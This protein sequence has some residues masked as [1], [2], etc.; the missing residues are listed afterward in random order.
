[1]IV[2]RL[3]MLGIT[4]L[5]LPM[6]I[7]TLFCGLKKD[8]NRWVFSWISGQVALWAGFLAICVP[9]ILLKKS[10]QLVCFLFQGY[11]ILLVCIALLVIFIGYKKGKYTKRVSRIHNGNDN[12]KAEILLWLIFG[13]LLIIQLLCTIMLAYEEGDDA[14][15]L[16]VSTYTEN[17][18]T[19]YLTI[20][21][22]GQYTALDAR[23]GLAPFPIWIAYLARISGIE[24]I[25]VA[26][27][28]LPLTLLGMCYG[29][30]YLMAEK[31]CGENKKNI[32]LFMI[33][34]ALLIMFGGYSL[35]TAENFVLV[36]TSQGKAV[37]AA[38]VI[39]LILY[40]FML[41]L[42]DMEKKK[43]PKIFLWIFLVLITA[44]ACLC[45]T[46]GTILVSIMIAVTG[47]SIAF[48][49]RN[50]RVLFPL[51]GCCFIPVVM[52]LLYFVVQ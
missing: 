51:A 41:L 14:F 18:N 52:A 11:T 32:P 43:K 29:I 36:R 9:L 4:L 22:T 39:P 7:G 31:L 6:L 33:M 8:G 40:W 45:S 10:F 30:Y 34:V 27:V 16:A 1:M 44:T 12:K 48:S 26:Q 23:H 28:L 42:D 20:P 46:L 38:I 13:I 50:W 47:L 3:F 37:I 25:T 21:Y 5:V 49:Y 15:Y 24:A 19:M 2:L 17:S 35:F